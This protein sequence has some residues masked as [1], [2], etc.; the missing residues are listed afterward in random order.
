MT[1][2]PPT[3]RVDLKLCTGCRS[4]TIACALSHEHHLAFQTARI[5]VEKSFPGMKS[6]IFKPVFCRMCRNAKC[7]AV[8]PTG[9]LTD[10]PANGLVNLN[11][12][13][14]NGCGECVTSC[15]F[16]AIW[17]DENRGVA[18]K[19]DLCGGDPACVRSCAPGALVFEGVKTQL[20]KDK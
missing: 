8:C 6:P 3:L 9:A 18:I 4:C 12:K 10:D 1:P 13:L 19:C 2:K 20:Q 17:L 7:I 15:P 16:D 11:A 5:R 14:C